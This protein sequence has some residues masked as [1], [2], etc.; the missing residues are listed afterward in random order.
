MRM[1]QRVCLALDM[2]YESLDK[3]YEWFLALLRDF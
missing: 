3:L 2:P 1:T